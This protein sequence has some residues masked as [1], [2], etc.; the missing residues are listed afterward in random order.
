MRLEIDFY[1][2]LDFF[3]FNGIN[4]LLKDCCLEEG[5]DAKKFPVVFCYFVRRL[6]RNRV[7]REI[8]IVAFFF[9]LAFL[10]CGTTFAADTT[11]SGEVYLLCKSETGKLKVINTTPNKVMQELQQLKDSANCN[12]TVMVN[13]DKGEPSYYKISVG[14]ESVGAITGKTTTAGNESELVLGSYNPERWFERMPV[15]ICTEAVTAAL[16][17]TLAWYYKRKKLVRQK[18]R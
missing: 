8:V 11:E 17:I 12:Y 3:R 4:R 7:N 1:L 10:F 9:A 15:L 13:D 5:S 2:H 18:V 6:R 16:L 14:D